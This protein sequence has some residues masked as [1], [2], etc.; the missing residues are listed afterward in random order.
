MV[1]PTK[2]KPKKTEPKPLPRLRLKSVDVCGRLTQAR[3]FKWDKSVQAIL[4][5]YWVAGKPL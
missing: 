4:D 5:A 2:N 3:N 1:I